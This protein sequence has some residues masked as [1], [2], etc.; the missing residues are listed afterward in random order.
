MVHSRASAVP[1]VVGAF[2]AGVCGCSRAAAT[3]A[4]DASSPSASR[5]TAS[6]ATAESPHAAPIPGSPP[7]DLCPIMTQSVVEGIF[8]GSYKPGGLHA[9][10]ICQY[11][12][13]G[14]GY[15]SVANQLGSL[16]Q[17]RGLYPNAKSIGGYGTEAFFSG[18]KDSGPGSWELVI[19]KPGD[20]VG[21]KYHA[22]K[23]VNP[24]DDDALAKLKK[25]ADATFAKL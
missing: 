9:A 10:A 18:P 2:L 5:G 7:S 21:Y 1:L 16:R 23:G 12:T 8:G 25:L 24:S 19:Q 22:K 3:D 15:V 14:D 4:S 11:D 13:A 6:S 17:W 20:L